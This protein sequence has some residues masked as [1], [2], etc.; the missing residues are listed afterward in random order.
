MEWLFSKWYNG[1]CGKSDQ[2]SSDEAALSPIIEL[3]EVQDLSVS[4]YSLS[5]D[6]PLVVI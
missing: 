4:N 3:L 2:E 1:T 6:G 5:G